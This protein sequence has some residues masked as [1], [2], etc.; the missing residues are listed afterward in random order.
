MFEPGDVCV[1]LKSGDCVRLVERLRDGD[2]TAERADTHSA[3][4][5]NE[6]ALAPSRRS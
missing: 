2:W 3:L 4:L 1:F 5:I 6:R